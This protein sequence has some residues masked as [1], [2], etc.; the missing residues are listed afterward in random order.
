MFVC[1]SVM[2]VN[3]K[4]KSIKS[5]T[6]WM[7]FLWRR[8]ADNFHKWETIHSYF[9]VRV[10]NPNSIWR[11]YLVQNGISHFDQVNLWHQQDRLKL[12]SNISTGPKVVNSYPV[13]RSCDEST[14][15]KALIMLHVSIIYPM[16]RSKDQ[17]HL[18]LCVLTDPDSDNLLI[19]ICMRVPTLTKF[20]SLIDILHWQVI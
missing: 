6:N 8:L 17:H 7:T 15:K 18:Q 3:I 20:I 2:A 9:Y 19:C 1:M 4:L 10:W 12:V 5:T 16:W 13:S 14:S 11:N